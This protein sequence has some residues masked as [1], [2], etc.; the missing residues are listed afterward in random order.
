MGTPLQIRLPKCAT[1]LKIEILV[2]HYYLGPGAAPRQGETEQ[3]IWIFLQIHIKSLSLTP[4]YQ[5]ITIPKSY[6]FHE[7]MSG[8]SSTNCKSKST[9]GLRSVWQ[10]G[11]LPFFVQRPTTYVNSHNASEARPWTRPLI[12]AFRRSLRE[13]MAGSTLPPIH[14]T[15]LPCQIVISINYNSNVMFI[16]NNT[17]YDLRTM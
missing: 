15:F 8:C 1:Y 16:S 13:P 3:R 10:F 12:K 2:R 11:K 7:K 4:I 17:L 9:N 14:I 6:C 5:I